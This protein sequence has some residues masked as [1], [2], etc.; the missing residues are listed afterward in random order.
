MKRIILTLLSTVITLIVFAQEA[1][2]TIVVYYGYQAIDT[3]TIS[4]SSETYLQIQEAESVVQGITDEPTKHRAIVEYV[5]SHP[6]SDGSLY[7]M[8]Y[9]SGTINFKKCLPVVS[10]RTRNSI[11]KRLFDFYTAAEVETDAYLAKTAEAITIGKEATGF[12]LED[13]NGNMLTLS[14]LRGKYVML[15]FWGSWCGA[16]IKSFPHLKAFYEQH[17]DKLEVI[18]IACK[19]HELP[20]L[21]VLNGEGTNDV[22]A[23]YGVQAYPTYVLIAPDGKILQWMADDPDTFDLYFDNQMH[24][25]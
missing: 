12:S 5:L 9:L 3:I 19:R 4:K 1:D 2:T 10:E 7:L 6:D 17:R 23:L 13:I 24:D 14:S 25:K 8:R 22:A 21:H 11:L 15:D 18:G 20:W 16:C